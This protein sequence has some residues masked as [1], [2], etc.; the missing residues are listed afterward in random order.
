MP[1]ATERD[2]SQVAEDLI[3]HAGRFAE[4][5]GLP[6]PRI[7][8]VEDLSRQTPGVGDLLIIAPRGTMTVENARDAAALRA[9]GKGIFV[10]TGE[11]LEPAVQAWLPKE[12]VH[13]VGDA[14]QASWQVGSGLLSLTHDESPE[15]WVYDSFTSSGMSKAQALSLANQ[16]DQVTPGVAWDRP[17]LVNDYRC[18]DYVVNRA[19]TYLGG[20]I[21][22]LSPAELIPAEA[23]APWTYWDRNPLCIHN[24]GTEFDRAIMTINVLLDGHPFL[25]V[26]VNNWDV[27][28]HWDRSYWVPPGQSFISDSDLA[29]KQARSGGKP[30]KL[31]PAPPWI[32]SLDRKAVEFLDGLMGGWASGFLN[33]ILAGGVDWLCAHGKDLDEAL[34]LDWETAISVLRGG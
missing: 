21:R 27:Q 29:W 9:S 23:D 20:R 2:D 1:V 10:I 28:D 15:T 5:R 17:I 3:Y 14:D 16:M 12:C 24:T 19:G 30:D 11:P 33:G 4:A 18:W 31:E 32:Q 34:Q 25:L 8:H 26:C 22:G 7:V 13:T 6:E